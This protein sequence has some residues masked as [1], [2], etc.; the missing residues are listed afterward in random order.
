MCESSSRKQQH[1][2][3]YETKK[4]SNRFIFRTYTICGT[5][6]Y[7]APEVAERKGHN[8]VADW[9][10]LGVLIYEL[11]TGKSS[12]V[13]YLYLIVFEFVSDTNTNG[14]NGQNTNT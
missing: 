8:L 6:E 9:W 2:R 11:M 14:I 7:I 3:F 13:L 4:S 5:P 10:S 12:F 1:L